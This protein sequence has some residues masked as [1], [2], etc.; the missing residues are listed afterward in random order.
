MEI[1]RLKSN[2][3]PNKRHLRRKSSQKIHRVI[4]APPLKDI[5]NDITDAKSTHSF[6][7]SPDVKL[8]HKI[9][10]NESDSDD[11]F[12]DQIMNSNEVMNEYTKEDRSRSE[13]SGNSDER[14]I[15]AR[16]KYYQNF[17]NHGSRPAF[18]LAPA[19]IKFQSSVPD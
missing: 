11:P 19:L 3:S 18:S 9:E 2:G 7:L 8:D 4:K 1:K 15:K 5:L 16:D 12:P 6:E 10:L 17:Q 13:I 14:R